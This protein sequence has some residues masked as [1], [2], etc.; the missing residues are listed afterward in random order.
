MPFQLKDS[1]FESQSGFWPGPAPYPRCVVSGGAGQHL[2]G[3]STR[4]RRGT[5]GG[6]RAKLEGEGQSPQEGVQGFLAGSFQLLPPAG[7]SM[8]STKCVAVTG[9]SYGKVVSGT[10]RVEVWSS[11]S[12]AW[13]RILPP[14][15]FSFLCHSSPRVHSGPAFLRL[16]LSPRLGG[17]WPSLPLFP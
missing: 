2:P 3:L 14:V 6:P 13:E 1:G 5:R 11:T 8:V 9:S 16:P 12:V 15:S 7:P 17:L 10:S 4:V